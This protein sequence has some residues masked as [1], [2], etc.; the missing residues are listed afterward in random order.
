MNDDTV[1]W[2]RI[3]EEKFKAWSSDQQNDDI[4]ILAISHFEEQEP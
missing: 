1:E 2:I 3:L 4:S